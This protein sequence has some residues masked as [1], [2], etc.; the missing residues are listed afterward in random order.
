MQENHSLYQLKNFAKDL[1]LLYVEDDQ[2]SREN[3]K[4]ILDLFFMDIIIAYDG[5]DG[6]NK[7]VDNDV[8]F[9]ITDINMP[10]LNGIDMIKKIREINPDIPI[11]VFSAY[12]ETAYFLDSIKLGVNGYLIKPIESE[13]FVNIVSDKIQKLYLMQQV[14]DYQQNLEKKVKSQVEELM[15]K[16][17]MLIQQSKLASMG[18]M[19]DIIAHQ[20]KQPLNIIAMHS[21][22]VGEDLEDDS[23]NIDKKMIH[24]CYLNTRSQITHLVETLDEFRAFFRPND[25]IQELCIK[26]TLRSVQVLLKDD[27]IKNTMTLDINCPDDISINANPG[28]VKHIFINLINNARD[29]FNQN[30]IKSRKITINAYSNK[31]QK[32]V[33]E[34]KDNAGGIPQEIIGDIFKANFTTKQNSGGTGMG[35]YMSK[36][37]AE[38]NYSDL[39][40]VNED[41]GAKF[42]LEYKGIAD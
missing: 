39:R 40:V 32:A 10:K 1:T 26:E 41:G 34:I 42:I 28:E 36:F 13:Q 27:L 7:Y 24:S 31:E 35:L 11:L 19:M 30:G 5:E 18:E 21:S 3:T 38:K 14:K 22:L 6:L 29:A 33:V 12:N 37:I 25:N 9:I 15:Q 8:D 23:L 16:D 2:H 20:W 17:N 4:S